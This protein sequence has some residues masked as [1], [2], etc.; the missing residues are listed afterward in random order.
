MTKT[1]RKDKLKKLINAGKIQAK[2]NYHLTDDYK[3]DYANN[4]GKTPWLPCRIKDSDSAHPI[5]GYINLM[6]CDFTFK[7][8]RCID[9]GTHM[10]FYIHSNLSY[11]LKLL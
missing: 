11:D 5:K 8:A 1:I 9:Y 6:P 2:C 7:T 3:Y 4:E 10:T